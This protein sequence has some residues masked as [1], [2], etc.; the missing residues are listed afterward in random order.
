MLETDAV[1]D[2][3]ASDS[4]AIAAEV[5]QHG[6]RSLVS[7]SP[8]AGQPSSTGWGGIKTVPFVPRYRDGLSTWRRSQVCLNK[9]AHSGSVLAGLLRVVNHKHLNGGLR[10]F[11]FQPQL[12]FQGS[13]D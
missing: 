11:Q 1:S 13:E 2:V 9:A 5:S 12:F 3:S 10:G 4:T 8:V 7:V 6:Q